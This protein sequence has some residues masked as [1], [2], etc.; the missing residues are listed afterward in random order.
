VFITAH[1]ANNA[2][3]ARAISLFEAVDREFVA[4]NLLR[5]EIIPQ[6]AYHKRHAEVEFYEACL[7]AVSVWIDVDDKLIAESMRYA[8]RYGLHTIDALHITAALRAECEQFITTERTSKP[9]FRVTELRV[10]RLD[11]I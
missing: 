9:L 3:S 5:L 1:D 11:S 2:N 7:G 10:L 6:G 8:S 4:T